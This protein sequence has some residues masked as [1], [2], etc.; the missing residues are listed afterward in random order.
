MLALWIVYFLAFVSEDFIN[1][2]YNS[3]QDTFADRVVRGRILTRDGE[4]LAR[5]DIDEYGN[6]ERVYP[7]GRIFAHVVG[8]STNGKSGLESEANFHLLSSHEFFIDQMRKEFAGRKNLGDD[9]TTTLDLELQRAAYEALGDRRGAVFALEPK[10]GKILA[11]VSK[12]D[13]DPNEIIYDWDYLINDPDDS[14][15]LNRVTDGAY[16]PGS[17]FKIVT[18]LDYYRTRGTLEGYSFNCEGQLTIGE[19][20]IHCYEYAVHGQEDLT[21]AFAWSCNCAFARLGVDLGANSLISVA[22]DLLFNERLPL[23]S[24]RESEF[25]LARDA[26][27]R[28]L[29]QTAIGQGDTLCSPAHMALIASAIANG[30]VL[31]K[32]YLIDRVENAQGDLI[33]QVRPQESRRLLGAQEAAVLG[34]LMKE[35]VDNGTAQAL[36]WN[37]YQAW[38]KTGSAEFDEEGNS[39]S[40]FVGYAGQEEPEIVLSIIIENGGAGSESAVPMAAELFDAYLYQ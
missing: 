1:S 4:V 19:D 29:M 18:A 31:M 10:T 12:P 16:P 24:Y 39:H 17:V 9:V 28:M 37:G 38:G 33:K 30:G 7:Y 3:R 11:M 14:S 22:Q 6:E 36:G 26:D 35:V 21:S 34:G 32:P 5:T 25:T 40:W 15:L 20:T 13:F 27:T 23:Y 8:F 2:P